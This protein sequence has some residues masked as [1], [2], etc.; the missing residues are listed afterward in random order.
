MQV[1]YWFEGGTQGKTGGVMQVMYWFEGGTQ[2]KT[3]GGHASHVL[4]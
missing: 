1:M 4:V 3:G 2:G